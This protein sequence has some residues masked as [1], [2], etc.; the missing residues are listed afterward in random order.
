[1][2]WRML[3][4]RASNRR[5]FRWEREALVE[6]SGPH[7]PSAHVNTGAAPMDRAQVGKAGF[8]KEWEL[9][10]KGFLRQLWLND[11]VQLC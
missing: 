2:T 7:M 5:Y 9:S 8:H 11:A 10:E 1:M 6:Q 4:V 3:G